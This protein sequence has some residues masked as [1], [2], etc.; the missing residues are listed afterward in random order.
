MSFLH[1]ILYRSHILFPD[2][3]CFKYVGGVWNLKQ[4]YVNNFGEVPEYG[5]G[6][7]E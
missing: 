1:H 4:N 2:F 6:K 3:V 7:S 5:Y